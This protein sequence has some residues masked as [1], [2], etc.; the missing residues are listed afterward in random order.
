MDFALAGCG[1]A[2]EAERIRRAAGGENEG[3]EKEAEHDCL[4]HGIVGSG[5]CY[6]K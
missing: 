1:G 2:V 5:Q 4:F 3:Q 6:C